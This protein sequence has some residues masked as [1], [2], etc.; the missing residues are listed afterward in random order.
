VG[1]EFGEV[2]GL[3]RGGIHERVG[4]GLLM[5]REGLFIY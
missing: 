4:K 1:G 2:V 3:E 5:D